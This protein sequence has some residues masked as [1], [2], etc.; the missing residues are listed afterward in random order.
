MR[1]WKYALMLTL[2]LLAVACGDKEEEETGTAPGLDTDT[3]DETEECSGTAPVV[4][5]VTCENSGIQ[6]HF[7]T[8]EDTVTMTIMAETSDADGDLDYYTFELFFDDEIDGTVDTST[9]VFSPS[10]GSVD[11]D[12]CEAGLVNLG[13][14]L[15]L[16]GGDPDYDTLYE[17]G[18][19][20]T[21]GG[22]IASEVMVVECYTPTSDG[23][24]GGATEG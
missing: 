20:V 18:V 23:E 19:I 10:S 22:G 16:A 11:V 2:P 5:A 13:T 1:T 9:S 12:A 4:E 6:P 15:Y 14:V 24:D 17:W 7:E 21:D 3:E 8:G